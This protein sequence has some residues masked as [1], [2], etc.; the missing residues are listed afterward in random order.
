MPISF[1]T[2]PT[3]T[4]GA[5]PYRIFQRNGSDQASVRITGTYSGSP[6]S[7]EYRWRGG[8]WSTLVASPS[9]GT[10]DAT[11]TLQ[12]PGQGSLEV[13]FSNDFAQAASIVGVGVGDVYI[14]AGQ[15]NN[16]GMSN[17]AQVA[18]V[19]PV[20]GWV[21]T[22]F[23]KANVWRENVETLGQPFDD[24]TGTAYPS[25]YPATTVFGSYFGALATLIMQRGFPVAFVPCALGST[26][27]AQWQP[28]S[29][30]L[31][32]TMVARAN[33]VGAHRG[34]IWWQGEAEANTG[35]VVQATF[36]SQ[37]N[38]I[39]NTWV[40][41]GP[42]TPWFLCNI[43]DQGISGSVPTVRAAIANVAATNANVD[44]ICDMLGAWSTGQVH[45]NAVGAI[46]TVASRAYGMLYDNLAAFSGTV[47]QSVAAAAT[48]TA[49]G[50]VVGTA[51]LQQTQG[52]SASASNPVAAAS[53]LSVSSILAA[54]GN[55]VKTFNGYTMAEIQDAVWDEIINGF[56]AR[57]IWQAWAEYQANSGGS[58]WNRKRTYLD[59]TG[60]F[61]STRSEAE[62][63]RIV[64]AAKDADDGGDESPAAQRRS[65]PSD[66]KK[67]AASITAG[68][69]ILSALGIGGDGAPA[70]VLDEEG[71][72]VVAALL[73]LQGA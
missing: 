23:D 22:E 7:I 59:Y 69:G 32:T 29:Q 25:A 8:S 12:G 11:V 67:P 18:P 47:S 56:A 48:V 16:V 73:L 68:S 53:Q 17:S 61:V 28:P 3:T 38:N 65:A 13:R 26:N 57:Q 49:A 14:V 21:A 42:G 62:Q 30:V 6:T 50:T 15:S 31:Y 63:S 1:T 43:N 35:G 60:H 58:A 19:P 37:L 24:R 52:L 36:E 64:V 55:V 70:H 2:P 5:V 9:G 39:I 10:F 20:A 71:A 44:G 4:N 51:S 72:F 54:I 66:R 34:V 33:I 45:Y 40:S 27:L 46:N 41:S